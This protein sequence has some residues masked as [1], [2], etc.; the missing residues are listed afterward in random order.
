MLPRLW[1]KSVDLMKPKQI[2]YSFSVS[3]YNLCMDKSELL[4][5]QLIACEELL[6]SSMFTVL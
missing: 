4:L 2:T 3:N 1:P 6:T 5:S